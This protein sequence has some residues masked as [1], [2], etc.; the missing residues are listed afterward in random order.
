MFR[1]KIFLVAAV[2]TFALPGFSPK[3]FCDDQDTI[4][5]GAYLPMTGG[6][7]AYGKMEWAG[8][9][10][11]NSMEPEALGKK[12]SVV[13]LDTK[14]DQIESS[15][16][17]SLLIEMKV[18]GIIGEAISADTMAGN[19]I[20]EK[21]QIPSI[22]PTA[23]NPLVT[24]GKEYAFRVCFTDPFQGEIAAK[25]ALERLKA[26]T[27]ALIIDH[28]QDY[29]VGLGN[30]FEKEF[31]KLGGKVVSKTFIQTGDQDFSA[32]LSSV[33]SNK[34][35][36]IYAPIY[37]VEDALLAKQ[38]RDLGINTPILTGDGAQADQLIEIGGK[39][40]EGMYFTA[41]FHK[42]AATGDIAKEF[43]KV[44]EAKY[45][46][47]VSAFTALGADAYFLLID[48]VKRAG[49]FEGPKVR[50]ALSKTKDFNGV[51]GPMTMGPDGNPI[52]SMVINKVENGKFVYY[53]TIKP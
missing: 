16:A 7:A 50:D 35:D 10:T 49:S 45:K 21:A 22:S 26:R 18:A 48:A 17:V 2:L 46:Q 37:Y 19:P 32:Q 51:S 34:P 11:A 27:A 36:L 39:A 1:F 24:Q 41:H 13:L 52:K 15:N 43:N 33:E 6:V 31:R 4:K 47:E 8:I 29:S 25:F 12:I 20:S 9:Q 5:I 40:V 42:D 38:A 53:M 28:S 14:S 3:A 30:Y 23:T 44:Y